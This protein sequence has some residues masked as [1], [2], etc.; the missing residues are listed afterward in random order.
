MCRSIKQLRNPEQDTL[1]DEVRAAALQFV[2][3]I[4]GFHKPSK[5]NEQAFQQ[6]IA[7]IADSSQRLLHAVSSQTRGNVT[8]KLDTRGSHADQRQ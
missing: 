2:R 8:A 6:A 7:E 3:K 1:P 5:A 4:T